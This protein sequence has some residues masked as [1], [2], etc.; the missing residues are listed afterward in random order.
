LIAVL[1]SE[2]NYHAVKEAVLAFG[3]ALTKHWTRP[4]LQH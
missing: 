3:A 4:I 1:R 2:Q